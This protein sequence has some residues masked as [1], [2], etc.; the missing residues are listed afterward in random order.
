M[1]LAGCLAATLPAIGRAQQTRA[2]APDEVARAVIRADSAGDWVT[3]LRLA[4]PEALARFRAIHVFQLRLLSEERAAYPDS[5]A[6]DSALTDPAPS[7]S[8]GEAQWE[9]SRQ[10]YER[11]LLDSMFQVPSVDS[12]AHTLPDTVFARWIRETRRPSA[13][14][15]APRATPPRPVWQV[16]GTVRASDTLAYV[17]M[18]RAVVQPLGH[19]PEMFR[20]FP[21]ETR[22]TEVMVLRRVGKPWRSMLDG[23]G[24]PFVG[25][26]FQD[27]ME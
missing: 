21:H 23:T 4:H 9:R 11:F 7:D 5:M 19:M 6:A 8:T 10:E 16:I 24:E 25:G 15:S 17:V 20:D 26:A 3:L 2:L 1:I 22:Q 13:R 18:E 27:A 14:D 12:L